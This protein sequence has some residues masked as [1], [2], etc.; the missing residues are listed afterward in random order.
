MAYCVVISC[1]VLIACQKFGWKVAVFGGG[2]RGGSGGRHSSVC[3]VIAWRLIVSS[4]SNNFDAWS[5][6]CMLRFSFYRPTGR[7]TD[8]SCATCFCFCCCVFFCEIYLY[9]LCFSCS[10][11]VY[12]L[13]VFAFLRVFFSGGHG[14]EQAGVCAQGGKEHTAQDRGEEGG[15][16]RAGVGDLG[17]PTQAHPVSVSSV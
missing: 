11:P 17:E 6:R 2:D 7:P 9:F 1:G 12:L 8:R 14:A 10:F 3:C 5:S 4:E 13:H 15:V 16:R